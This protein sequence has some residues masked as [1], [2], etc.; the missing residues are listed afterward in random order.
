MPEPASTSDDSGRV[1]ADQRPVALIGMMG[2]G[3]STVGRVLG[4]LLGLPVSDSDAVIEQNSGMSVAEIFRTKGEQAF[5]DQEAKV[6]AD[7]LATPERE[8]IGVAGGAVL[9]AETRAAL[10]GQ[11]FVVWLRA[12]IEVLVERVKRRRIDRP[13]IADDPD[14]AMRRIYVEREPIYESLADLVVD[15][16]ERSPSNIAREI[17]DALTASSSSAR[18]SSPPA[19]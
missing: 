11:A 15:V 14:G 6:L 13:M 4:N 3:K 8:I 5:R 7:A 12:P 1:E 16:H 10:K 17:A 18:A 19:P 9:R 2:A